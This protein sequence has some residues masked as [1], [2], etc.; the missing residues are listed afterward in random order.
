MLTTPNPFGQIPLHPTACSG[1]ARQGI[2]SIVKI[3]TWHART[4]TNFELS[5][6]AW[7]RKPANSASK[8]DSCPVWL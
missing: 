3:Q 2:Q 6:Q 5:I 7:A 8:G 4:A 1:A